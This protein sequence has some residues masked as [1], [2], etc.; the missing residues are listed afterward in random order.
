MEYQQPNKPG[1]Y[2]YHCQL[3]KWLIACGY[4]PQKDK[5][6]RILDLGSGLGYFYFILKKLG[7]KQVF[8]VDRF[9][10]FKE[11][12]KG[13]VAKRLPFKDVISK[14]VAE[15]VIDHEKF[16][17]E[18]RRV[19]RKGGTIIVMAPNA[20]KLAIG[21]FYNDYTHVMPYTRK[22][23]FEALEM[24]GF[25]KVCVTRLRAIPFLWRY[26][27]KAFDMLFSRRRNN[28]LAIAKK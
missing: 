3:V 4:I 21:D 7:Y 25:T 17:A 28:L 26:T 19:L 23:L 9:P 10:Q 20:E 1:E 22:S 24:N 2:L 12:I 6:V 18:Q 27:L 14:D 11:C 16:F 8:A 13:D 5:S 15:H